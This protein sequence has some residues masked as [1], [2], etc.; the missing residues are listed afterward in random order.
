MCRGLVAPLG[1]ASRGVVPAAKC[2]DPTCIPNVS[3]PSPPPGFCVVSSDLLNEVGGWAGGGN[4]MRQ[5]AVLAATVAALM[6]A[7][8][9]VGRAE[10]PV[11]PDLLQTAP[12]VGVKPSGVDVA[13][14]DR[15]VG[16]PESLFE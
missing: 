6:V 9:A 13:G 11:A 2:S 14:L 16:V 10:M 15:G 3:R 1:A 12:T 8:V 5:R 7:G 4:G